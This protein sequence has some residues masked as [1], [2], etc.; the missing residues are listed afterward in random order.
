MK[1]ETQLFDLKGNPSET[2]TIDEWWLAPDQFRIEINSGDLHEVILTGEPDQVPPGVH[3]SAFLLRQLLTYE[4]SPLV[5]LNTNEKISEA[6]REINGHSLG[7]FS[8]APVSNTGLTRE[9]TYCREPGGNNIRLI[10]SPDYTAVR[11]RV[12]S[13][14]S[15]NIALDVNISYMGHP[16]VEGKV[17]T[18]QV[19]DSAAAG[20]PVIKVSKVYNSDPHIPS[21]SI[22]AGHYRSAPAIDSP[23]YAKHEHISGVVLL[24]CR[25]TR[26]G[27]V[28]DAD[29][30]ASSNTIFDDAAKTGVQQW[31]FTPFTYK[32]HPISAWVLLHVNFFGH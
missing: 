1:L 31:L 15:T 22:V 29:V 32:D 2:G 25:I 14:G 18:L 10:V 6:A 3:R 17:V 12:G 20:S 8:L 7:C 28:D 23:I 26:D 9:T 13:F 11:N 27:K 5:L 30:I 4:V 24:A 19:F 16:A 21:P